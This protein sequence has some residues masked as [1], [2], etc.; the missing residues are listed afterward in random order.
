ML[1]N[2]EKIEISSPHYV[3][4][5]DAEKLYFTMVYGRQGRRLKEGGIDVIVLYI[6]IYDLSKKIGNND[7]ENI[8]QS[9][10]RIMDLRIS[11]SGKGIKDITHFLHKVFYDRNTGYIQVLVDYNFYIACINEGLRLDFEKYGVLNPVSKNLYCYLISNS[12]N[13]FREELLIDRTNISASR[14]DKAQSML[15]KSLQELK[16]KYIIEDFIIEKKKG[17]RFVIIKQFKRLP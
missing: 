11:Y 16:D 7:Y 17:Q 13:K 8:L 15:R 12:N 1:R 10:E 14:K 4:T 9:L 5:T 2:G 3:T 6:H